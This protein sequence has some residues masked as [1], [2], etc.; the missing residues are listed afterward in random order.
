MRFELNEN[1]IFMFSSVH[2]W[3]DTRIFNKELKSLADAGK[4]I[5]YYA[6]ESKKKH[7]EIDI[8][9]L[10][11]LNLLPRGTKFTRFKRWNYLLNQALESDARY[12]HF[13]D[14]ELLYVAKKI[15]KL[16]PKS[17]IIYDMH[18]YFPGQ[19]T[20]KEWIP[21]FLRF[22][23]SQVVKLLEKK[24]MNFCDGVIFAESSYSKYH[25]NYQGKKETILNYPLWKKYEKKIISSLFTLIYVGDITEDRNIRGMIE[26]VKNLKDRGHK[27]FQ[28]KLIGSIQSTL[29]ENLEKIILDYGISDYIHWYGRISYEKIWEYYFS[30]D[31]GLCLLY[32][33]PNYK[34][35][36]PT[37]LFE[38]MAAG[39]PIV[40]SN[41]P[42]WEKLVSDTNSGITVDPLNNEQ[43]VAAIEEIKT[44]KKMAEAFSENGRQA[45]EK[46]Y[47]WKTEEKKLLSFY[48]QLND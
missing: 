42:D 20:T 2:V 25:S 44:N 41:F 3:M 15:K 37:K 32:P 35:S 33:I 23:T 10:I 6:I 24:W 14:P 7:R 26:L 30:A 46:N 34:N 36:L 38:Y 4:T 18:E 48:K 39:L 22:S 31:I 21:F 13:H 9:K 47:N 16:K 27:Q 19:I 40:A 5:D 45:F 12:Y 11:T 28:L 8:P 29:K 17:V 43:I 1:K